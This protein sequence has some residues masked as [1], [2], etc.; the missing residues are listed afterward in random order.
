MNNENG[1]SLISILI[2]VIVAVIIMS[3]LGY[4]LYNNYLKVEKAENSNFAIKNSEEKDEKEET[5]ENI[6]KTNNIETK[7]QIVNNGGCFVKYGDDLY[8]WKLNKNS[9]ENSALYGNY[10]ELL[11]AQ[12]ELIKRDSLGNE[13]IIY[14]GKG[15]ENIYIINNRIYTSCIKENYYRDS[16]Y[17]ELYTV[18]INGKDKVDLGEGI[19]R[20]VIDNYLICQSPNNEI[21][22][23]D[24]N[25]NSAEVIKSGVGFLGIVNNRVYYIATSIGNT[26]KNRL[27]ADTVEI[28][29]IENGKDSGII[30]TVDKSVFENIDTY[31]EHSMIVENFWAKDNMAYFYIAYVDGS[32]AIEQEKIKVSMDL[33]CQNI[34]TEKLNLIEGGGFK[35]DYENPNE[36][37][38]V[39]NSEDETITY[40]NKKI[41]SLSKLVADYGFADKTTDTY[42]IL[43]IYSY[44]ITDNEIYLVIDYGE[45]SQ[46][47][48]IGWRDGFNRLNTIVLSYDFKTESITELY[49]Y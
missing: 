46:E 40:N 4:L 28:G 26:Y 24:I 31:G 47:A 19:Y 12:N 23:I 30:E 44:D 5:N 7:K 8:Y 27:N 29:Y 16:L 36:P 13:T 2:G 17:R 14:S 43:D 42:T 21:L 1:N 22:K 3:I 41:I 6:V 18:T 34:K 39:K 25:T 20:G 9:R 37:Q 33:D 10:A 15:S 49:K 38:I 45:Y 48:S 35:N 11:D 32:A